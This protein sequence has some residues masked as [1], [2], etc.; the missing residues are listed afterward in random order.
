MITPPKASQA[1][2]SANRAVPMSRGR[3]V[4]HRLGAIRRYLGQVSDRMAEHYVH[5]KGAVAAVARGLSGLR[6]ARSGPRKPSS[7]S[8]PRTPPSINESAS[9]PPPAA[10]STNGSRP[11]APT[12]A[13]RTDASL[14][15]KL[16]L[17][18]PDRPT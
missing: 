12:S 10:P 3:I 1:L 8:P 2:N 18:T 16:A 13:S 17:P 9:S 4:R 5:L 6:R 11:P 15:S 7:G 14:T